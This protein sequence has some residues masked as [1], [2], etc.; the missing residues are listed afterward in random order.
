MNQFKTLIKKAKLKEALAYLERG[1][2]NP[3][4]QDELHLL[5][6]D[7]NRIEKENRMG[8]IAAPDY[9]Q[10]IRRVTLRAL[11]LHRQCEASSEEHSNPDNDNL[12]EKALNLVDEGKL[13]LVFDL[14]EESQIKTAELSLLKKEF[15]A[16][17]HRRNA[18]YYDQLKYGLE[19]GIPVTLNYLEKCKVFL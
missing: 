2:K 8:V 6:A 13:P 18:D 4:I 12:L 15:I 5:I 3:E 19:R 1:C 9:A 17:A 10:N 7:F 11:E 14:L 16:G